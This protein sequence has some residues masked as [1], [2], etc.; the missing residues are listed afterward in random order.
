MK[1][2]YNLMKRYIVFIVLSLVLPVIISAQGIYNNGGKIVI[3]SGATVYLNG[4]TGN[5]K[6]ETN[7]GDGAVLLS[8]TLRLGGNLTNNVAAAGVFTSPA[9]GSEVIF[10]GSAAQTM[11]GSSTAAF[12]FDKLT[13]N[14]SNGLTVGSNALVN[15]LLT[16]QSGII[17]TGSNVLTIGASG[18][19]SGAASTSYVSGKLARVIS[20]T[21]SDIAFPL[22]KGGNYRP[23]SLNFSTLTGTSTVLAEQLESLLPGTAPTNVT[24]FSG[25]Y[26]VMSQTGGSDL[27]FTLSLNSEGFTTGA[28]KKMIQGDGSTNTDYDVNFSS[29]NFTNT[30]PFSS[31]SNFGIG[32][33]CVGQ[34]V[35]FE[36]IAAKT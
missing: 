29:P 11:D 1:N 13:L 24:F 23:L 16:F 15:N 5:L 27:A 28:I 18:T 20:A 12:N 36:A 17:T 14:N 22:G 19:V 3:G 34:V 31:F 35:L 32:E 8:G 25:R 21:G 10:N 7:V 6:N 2:T 4:S 30:T 26:W 9:T 33:Y